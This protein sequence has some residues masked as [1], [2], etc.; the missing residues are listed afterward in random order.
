MAAE[1]N[2]CS[3]HDEFGGQVI[4]G[5]GQPIKDKGVENDGKRWHGE[6]NVNDAVYKINDALT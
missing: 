3:R 4:Q 6:P 5:L 1:K 2:A